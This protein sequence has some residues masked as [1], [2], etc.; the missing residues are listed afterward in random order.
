[1]LCFGGD[2][3]VGVF[4]YLF[5]VVLKVVFGLKCSVVKCNNEVMIIYVWIII[6]CINVNWCCFFVW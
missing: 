1:M 6:N 5:I 4:Y 2:I 3:F